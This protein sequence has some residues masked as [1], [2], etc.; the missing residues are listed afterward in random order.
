MF[1]RFKILTIR[2]ENAKIFMLIKMEKRIAKI[3]V[4]KSG[5]T[6][7]KDAKTY[8]VSLPTKWVNELNIADNLN[9]TAGVFSADISAYLAEGAGLKLVDGVYIDVRDLVRIKKLAGN[10]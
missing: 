9:I 10:I 4:G 2:Y 6:A 8:K 3:I 1:I 5:G 7:G